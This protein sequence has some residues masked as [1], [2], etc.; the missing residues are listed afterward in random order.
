MFPMFPMLTL[1][2]YTLIEFVHITLHLMHYINVCFFS[3][4][5][6]LSHVDRMLLYVYM[7]L[8]R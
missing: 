2:E 5:Y 3:K 8:D 4:L 1:Y 6:Q 7:L